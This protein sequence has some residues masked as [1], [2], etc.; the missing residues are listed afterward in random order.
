MIIYMQDNYSDLKFEWDAGNRSKNWDKHRIGI[1]QIEEVFFNYPLVL[2]EDY[3][4]S[5]K[6]KRL[7]SLG[8]DNGFKLLTISFTIRGSN[9]RVISARFMN[10]KEKSRYEKNV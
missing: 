6:E 5:Q 4:H 2:L 1:N 9:I 8:H 7:Y 10:R 3:T